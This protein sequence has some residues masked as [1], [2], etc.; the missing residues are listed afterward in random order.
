MNIVATVFWDQEISFR[1]PC[2]KESKG[3]DELV[4]DFLSEG[5]QDCFKQL[6][7]RY[8]DKVFRLAAS[9]MG[10][11]FSA[12]AEG[13]TQEVF[14]Q[15]FKK[16]STFRNESRFATWLFRIAYN[17]ALE[18]K[19]KKRFKI[20][21]KG[22]DEL[23]NVAAPLDQTDPAKAVMKQQQ[24]Q[25]VLQSL[26]TLDEPYRTVIYLHYWMKR[27]VWEIAQSLGTQPGTIKS[28]LFRARKQL[29]QILKKDKD[30]G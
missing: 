26:E 24:N 25:K 30:D 3:D 7:D 22:V 20:P 13:V 8:K 28:H 9:V 23:S 17:M 12:E 21:H 11:G 6:V 10:P 1:I 16:L 5:A 19:R 15:V 4:R 14:L 29:A 18:R 27:P 2:C